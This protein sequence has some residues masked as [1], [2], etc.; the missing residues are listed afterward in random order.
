MKYAL[1]R[2]LPDVLPATVSGHERG[3]RRQAGRA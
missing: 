2:F 3:A 1:I